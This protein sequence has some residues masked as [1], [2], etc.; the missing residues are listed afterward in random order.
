L[1]IWL[2]YSGRAEGFMKVKK[3]AL[4]LLI[5]KSSVYI[6]FKGLDLDL[7]SAISQDPDS[8]SVDPDP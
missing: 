7:L 1:K 8:K 3:I 4:L 5:K 2:F 6:L